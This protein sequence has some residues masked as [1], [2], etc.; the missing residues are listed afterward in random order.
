[1]KF[2]TAYVTFR[3]MQ[4]QSSKPSAGK[5]PVVLG[6]ALNHKGDVI[7]ERT[8]KGALPAGSGEV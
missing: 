3:L 1:M 7:E 4:W 6:Q 5:H 8:D 2:D